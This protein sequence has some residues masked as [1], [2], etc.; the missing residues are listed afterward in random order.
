VEML[1]RQNVY[2]F[3]KTPRGVI[4]SVAVVVGI[5]VVFR[6]VIGVENLLPVLLLGACALMHLFMPHGHG[7]GNDNGKNGHE[8]DQK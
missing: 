6:E 2:N 8:S 4:I 5:Y 7:H 1:S 3:I